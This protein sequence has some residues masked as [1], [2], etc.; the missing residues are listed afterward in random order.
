MKKRL[1]IRREHV[2]DC[3]DKIYTKEWRFFAPEDEI[4]RRRALKGL[5]GKV[6]GKVF[7]FAKNLIRL[8]VVTAVLGGAG[9]YA[10]EIYNNYK[11]E[12][13]HPKIAEMKQG[14]LI[15]DNKYQLIQDINNPNIY[16]SWD[17]NFNRKK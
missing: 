6:S 8:S 1:Y 17:Y 10:H 5:Y 14:E 2:A 3:R 7:D 11:Q 13:S 16:I 9:W 4:R 12:S 15:I